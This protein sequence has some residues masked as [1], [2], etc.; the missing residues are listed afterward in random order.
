MVSKKINSGDITIFLRPDSKFYSEI[1]LEKVKSSV[2]Q[3]ITPL[4][5][6]WYFHPEYIAGKSRTSDEGSN[7]R[8]IICSNEETAKIVGLRYDMIDEYAN[9]KKGINN[10]P[11]IHPEGFFE[12]TLKKNNIKNIKV[13]V[14]FTLLRENGDELGDC[15]VHKDPFWKN[16]K[17][18]RKIPK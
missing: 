12:W 6:N 17:T 1:P 9:K 18:K 16:K 14:C 8:L 13:D 3:V 5:D 11:I 4:W 7:D 10:S 2:N 15:I